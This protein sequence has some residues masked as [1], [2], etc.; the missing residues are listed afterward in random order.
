MINMLLTH[1]FHSDIVHNQCE[2]DG[3][4]VMLPQAGDVWTFKITL[5]VQLLSQQFDC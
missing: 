3:A 1:I 4:C 2:Q 5:G